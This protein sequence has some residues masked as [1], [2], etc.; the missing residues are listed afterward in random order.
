MAFSGTIAATPFVTQK[1]IDNAFRRCRVRPEQITAE[2]LD[3]A[4]DVLYLL[5]SDLANNGIPLW[6]I[7]KILLPLYEGVNDVVLPLGTIDTLNQNLRTIQAASGTVVNTATTSTTTFA[8][9]TT[10]IM[11]GIL[12]SAASA[13]IALERWDGA[14]WILVQTETPTAV[15]GQWTWFDLAAFVSGTQFRV[16][17][18]SG[19]LSFTQIVLAD[20]WTEIPM[21][22]MNRDDWFNLPNRAFK[23]NQPLQ[24]WF[25]RQVPQPIIHMWP[26]PDSSVPAQKLI[27][28][29]R[30]RQIMDVGTLTE[31]IE[32]PQRWRKAIV[33]NLAVELAREIPEVDPAVIPDLITARDEAMQGA[34]NEERDNSPT[35]WAADISM[36]TR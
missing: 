22:R 17:A 4:S 25:D 21:A 1:I 2:Y 30:H 31:E 23:N 5:L 6:C 11:V 29:L 34:R 20:S 10:V 32:V 36:Y 16:R 24:F 3:T 26:A 18:T 27:S 19:V 8:G 13:P 28:M 9:A 14:Q 7:E 35:R 15:A 33:T 12:W